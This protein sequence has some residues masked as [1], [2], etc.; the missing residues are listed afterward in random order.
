MKIALCMG[1]GLA[2]AALGF[3][4]AATPALAAKEDATSYHVN[5]AHDG[6]AHFKTFKPKLTVKWSRN[7][8]GTVSYPLIVDGVVYVTWVPH[9]GT[10]YGTE[11]SALDLQTGAILWHQRIKGTYFISNATYDNGQIFVLNVDGQ[12][13]AFDAKTGAPGF[14]IHLGTEYS[15]ES[16]PVAADGTVYAAEASLYAVDETTATLNWMG[17]SGDDNVP[18]VNGRNVFVTAEPYHAKYSSH[19]KLHW[20]QDAGPGQTS[21]AFYKGRLYSRGGPVLDAKTGSV[22]T[23]LGALDRPAAFWSDNDGNDYRIGMASGQLSSVN[24]ASGSTAWNFLGDGSLVT[25]PIV[26]NDFVAIGSSSGTLY[27]LDA[28]TGALRSSLTLPAGISA[29]QEGCCTNP[30]IGMSAG[31]GALVVPG[32]SSISVLMPQ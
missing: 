6:Q 21:G 15:D 13:R 31:D 26:I 2:A 11:L 5:P 17:E 18:V 16:P 19:G 24:V 22:V 30:W 3:V 28:A 10:K 9:Q 4:L 29:G 1:T 32:G 23:T 20:E 12:L 25:A 27:M 7:M 8:G 14:S